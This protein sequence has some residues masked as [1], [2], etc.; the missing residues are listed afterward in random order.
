MI[1]SNLMRLIQDFDRQ[2]N[3]FL[4]SNKNPLILG[5]NLI[6]QITDLEPNSRMTDS[7]LRNPNLD[8][9]LRNHQQTASTNSRLQQL[10]D[11]LSPLPQLSLDSDLK[12]TTLI[13]NSSS[14]QLQGSLPLLLLDLDQRRQNLGSLQQP[15]DPSLANPPDLSSQNQKPLGSSQPRSQPAPGTLTETSGKLPR[16]RFRSL[17]PTLPPASPAFR[18]SSPSTL[19]QILRCC[20]PRHAPADG[21]RLSRPT[22]SSS[23]GARRRR[24]RR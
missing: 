3:K 1:D 2:E 17:P 11:S 21:Y 16:R 19:M 22:S 10:P 24:R 13:N 14:Q 7:G 5:L 6:N 23:N 20:H 9:G 15:R 12:K 4:D 8:L 18:T